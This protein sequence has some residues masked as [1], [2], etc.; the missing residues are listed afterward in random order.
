MEGPAISQ[1]G[2]IV[3]VESVSSRNERTINSAREKIARGFCEKSELTPSELGYIFGNFSDAAT[4]KIESAGLHGGRHYSIYDL[5]GHSVRG[6]VYVVTDHE[7]F[8]SYMS[9]RLEADFL[10]IN[11]NPDSRIRASFT[12]FLH[13]NKLHWSKCCR[14]NITSQNKVIRE[15]LRLLSSKT[16]KS[17]SDIISELLDSALLRV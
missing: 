3:T 6:M 14:S 4:I 11:P 12:A 1:S 17:H 13:E 16:G 7:R 9:T 10:K 8:S 2:Q 15:K 5:L